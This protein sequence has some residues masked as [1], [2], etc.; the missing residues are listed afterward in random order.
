M[1]HSPDHAQEPTGQSLL[2]MTPEQIAEAFGGTAEEEEELPEFLG[3]PT[4]ALTSIGTDQAGNPV[5]SVPG[6]PGALQRRV[7]GWGA[8]NAQRPVRFTEADVWRVMTRSGAEIQLMQ[9]ELEAAGLLGKNEYR[10]G[11]FDPAT[12]DAVRSWLAFSNVSGKKPDDLLTEFSALEADRK[13]KLRDETLRRSAA[14]IVR[15]DPATVRTTVKASVKAL[16]GRE[17]TDAE[18]AELTAQF[19]NFEA[20]DLRHQQAQTMQAAE[21]EAGLRDDLPETTDVD[22][23]ARLEEFLAERFAGTVAQ[24]QRVEEMQV[25]QHNVLRMAD[26]M[27]GLMRRG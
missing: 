21:F 25:G 1:P 7:G 23:E 5:G 9:E 20:E 24:N 17:P 22:P 18:M 16:I 10:P 2:D 3:I 14:Q 15:T 19:Q 8:R 27:A 6:R 11:I 13:A 26:Q 4:G 12:Q